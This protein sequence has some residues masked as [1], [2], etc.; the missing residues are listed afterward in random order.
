LD[1]KTMPGVPPHWALYVCVENTDATAAKATK[2]GGKILQDPFDVFEFGRMAVLQ[3]PTGAAIHI[4]QPKTHQAAGI[5]DVPGTFCWADLS[6]PDVNA[7]K[8]FYEAVFGW[9]IS[10]GEKDTS[11]YLH[12]QNGQQYIGGIPP[13]EHRSP[14]V[15]PHWLLY[16]LVEDTDAAT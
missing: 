3:D 13:C 12:I 10:P 16:F 15:P 14:K 4:W 7:A 11:G 5:K 9:K 8:S 1:P 2:A 6:T